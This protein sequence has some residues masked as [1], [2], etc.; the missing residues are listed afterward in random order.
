[1]KYEMRDPRTITASPWNANVVSHE[2]EEKL[3]A[4]IERN[5]FFKPI[6]I[7]LLDGG[8]GPIAHECIGGWH[9]NEQAIELGMDEVPCINLGV[10]S[11]E[12]AKEISLADNARYG[13]DDTLKLSE[14]LSELNAGDL[15]AVLPWSQRDISAITASLSVDIDDLDIDQPTLDEDEDDGE[16]ETPA[17]KLA[18]THQTMRFRNGLNDAARISDLIK[19]TMSEQGFTK[20]DDLTNAGDALAFLLLKDDND[21]AV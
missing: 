1:M 6:L 20:E 5:G 15:E 4:S 11:D 13:I 9:R 16:D 18:K 3:R 14:L 10:I 21:A 17:P 2:N 8:G 12:K 7:R 19:K